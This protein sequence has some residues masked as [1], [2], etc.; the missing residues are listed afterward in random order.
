MGLSVVELDMNEPFIEI[1]QIIEFEGFFCDKKSY[2][3]NIFFEKSL[4]KNIPSLFF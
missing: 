3:Y 1:P 2:F 4:E